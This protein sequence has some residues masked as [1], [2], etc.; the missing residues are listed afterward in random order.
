MAKKKPYLVVTYETQE[1]FDKNFKDI[2]NSG[3]E[4]G[5]E[6]GR[7]NALCEVLK[8]VDGNFSVVEIA[9]ATYENKTKAIAKW[10][11]EQKAREKQEKEDMKELVKDVIS[12]AE[13]SEK[14]F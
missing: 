9:N 11:K 12:E 4:S 1:D 6:D 8:M 7:V 10:R 13:K 14:E 2:Y 5:F 3:Y